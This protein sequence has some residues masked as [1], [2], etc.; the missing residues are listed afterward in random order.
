LVVAI[1]LFVVIELP[2]ASDAGRS[3]VGIGGALAM[4]EPSLAEAF[5]T[6]LIIKTTPA[7]SFFARRC[8][9]VDAVL[10]VLLFIHT[11][12]LI[13]S[14]RSEAKSIIRKHL[15]REIACRIVAF[16]GIEKSRSRQCKSPEK[17]LFPVKKGMM[18][19]GCLR[20]RKN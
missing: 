10:K 18:R 1:G 9:A 17:V 7:P 20:M 11:L 6:R 19:V 16:C 13:L 5:S 14:L 12:H 3:L 8:V 15:R 2:L 4:G